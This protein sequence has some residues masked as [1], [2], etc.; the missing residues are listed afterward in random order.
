MMHEVTSMEGAIEFRS[1][2]SGDN[3]FAEGVFQLGLEGGPVVV[4][5]A[6]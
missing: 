3:G 1:D 6:R 4:D 2:C 5:L